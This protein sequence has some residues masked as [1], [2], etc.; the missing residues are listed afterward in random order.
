MQMLEIRG[1]LCSEVSPMSTLVE[2]ILLNRSSSFY[3]VTASIPLFGL[4][5]T[6][7]IFESKWEWVMNSIL[8]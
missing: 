5:E 8:I 1:G 7:Y 2:G 6:F 3:V 4:Q